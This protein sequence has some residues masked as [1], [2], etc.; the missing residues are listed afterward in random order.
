MS[1]LLKSIFP[2]SIKFTDV[3]VVD[4]GKKDV[5]DGSPTVQSL[6]AGFYHSEKVYKLEQEA[7]FKKHWLLAIH[8]V[9]FTEPG[10]YRALFCGDVKFVIVL[11]SDGE[12]RAFHNRCPNCTS[13]LVG[14]GVNPYCITGVVETLSCVDGRCKYKLTGESAADQKNNAGAKA[15]EPL[16]VHIDQNGYVYVQED[17]RAPFIS[18]CS[19]LFA[20]I[21]PFP[22][23]PNAITWTEQLGAFDEQERLSGFEWDKYRYKVSW[24]LIGAQFNWKTLS[25]NYNECHHCSYTHPGFVKTTDLKT[26]AVFESEGVIEHYVAPKQKPA[27]GD[28]GKKFAFN[29]LYPSSSH[30][31]AP[32]YYH[33]V[34]IV[35]TSPTTCD[36]LYDVYQHRECPDDEFEDTLAF[37]K[38]VVDEDKVL[39]VN[40]QRG[41]LAGAYHSGPLHP[42]KEAGVIYFQRR[43]LS[44]LKKYV[45]SQAGSRQ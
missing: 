14:E 8:R 30:T 23:S 43:H 40:T 26:Y 21:D 38:Q 17:R 31:V 20:D 41:L 42:V 33:T 22:S 10:Q 44:V 13:E 7:V 18:M 29:Y 12:L 32:A 15:L 19:T 11:G 9:F 37:I 2:G 5:Q 24:G 1:W 27:P 35:P 45:E 28:E 6:P 39:C 34:R 3:S 25:D 16:S 36:V 4:V